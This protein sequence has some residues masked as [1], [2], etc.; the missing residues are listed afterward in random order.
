MQQNLQ[1]YLHIC[2]KNRIFA[3]ILDKM[4]EIVKRTIFGALF[5]G[6]VVGAILWHTYAYCGLFFL[7]GILAVD[8]FHRL[9]K[10]PRSLRIYSF[11]ATTSL[12]ATV[13]CFAWS[14]R[15]GLVRICEPALLKWW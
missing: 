3:K 12:W 13:L 2:K 5:V 6:C 15:Y 4:S 14:T 11:L 1:I 10:S 7:F 8:E 9:V